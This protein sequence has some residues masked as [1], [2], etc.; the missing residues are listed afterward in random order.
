VRMGPASILAGIAS[1]TLALSP[2]PVCMLK[3]GTR[4][5]LQWQILYHTGHPTYIISRIRQ[6]SGPW[7]HVVYILDDD[8]WAGSTIISDG[9][10]WAH[11]CQW[12]IYCWCWRMGWGN[13][14]IHGDG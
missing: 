14:I 3:P 11:V 5:P 12:Y 7:A 2:G 10:G 1:G 8:G 6:A 9:Y 4:E 13:M